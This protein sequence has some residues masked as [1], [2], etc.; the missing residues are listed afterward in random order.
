VTNVISFTLKDIGMFVL[1]GLLVV[2]LWYLILVLKSL[3][4]SVRDIRKIIKSNQE[5]VDLILNEAPGISKN[6][7]NISKEVSDT[8][9][10]FRGSIDNVAESTENI[11]ETLKENDTINKKLAS[12]FQTLNIFKALYEKHF[13]KEEVKVKNEVKDHT[14]E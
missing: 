9:I 10:K 4:L 6:A 13:G 5:N 7:N 2:I 11:T 1:W 3:Y 14:A 8:L 12:I